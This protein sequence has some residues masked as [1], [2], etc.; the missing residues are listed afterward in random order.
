MIGKGTSIAH[1]GVAIDY[2]I[3]KEKAEILEK[4]FVIGDNGTEIKSE[5]K[6]F[7]DLNSRTTNNDIAFILSPEPK[8]G[9]KLSDEDFREI[10]NDF[11]K[12]MKLEKNQA[13]ILKHKDTNHT[14]LHL[15]VNRID[16]NGKAYKDNFISKHSQRAADKIA[17]EKGLTRA[18][19][20]KE[21]NLEMSKAIRAEIL[22][23]HK[24]VAQSRPRDFEEYKAM[25]KASGVDVIPTVNKAGKLQGFKVEFE[26]QLFKA[27]EITE[28]KQ[29]GGKSK[30]IKPLTLSQMGVSTIHSKQ[31]PQLDIPMERERNRNQGFSR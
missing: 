27:S 21:Y 29:I 31:N 24:A 7:Q 22:H 14:H 18:S 20:V 4:R 26:N 16:S 13:I 25:M 17:Q 23:K 3:T 19:I 6:I 28:K 8:D 12:E 10:A 5:F 11:L 15:Y 30:T 9:K 1:G 2:A